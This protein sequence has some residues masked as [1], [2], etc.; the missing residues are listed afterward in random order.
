MHDVDILSS[1]PR[2][3]R[4]EAE[5]E[6]AGV[7]ERLTLSAFGTLAHNANAKHLNYDNYKDFAAANPQIT[8]FISYVFQ[9]CACANLIS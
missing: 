5:S 8:E 6:C 4:E 1:N 3:R 7:A 9:R 2:K